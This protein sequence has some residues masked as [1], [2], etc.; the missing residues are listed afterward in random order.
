MLKQIKKCAVF[1]VVAAGL[2][3]LVENNAS[4]LAQNVCLSAIPIA[5]V[6]G[7]LL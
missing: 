7:G 3:G 6:F 2:R 4:L 5:Y 1:L